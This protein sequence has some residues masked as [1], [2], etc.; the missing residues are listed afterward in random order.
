MSVVEGL[1]SLEPSLSS[2]AESM[3]T[4]ITT[5]KNASAK[6]SYYE[7]VRKTVAYNFKSS[8]DIRKLTGE[9]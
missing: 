1:N 8:F 6:G 5:C 7:I 2:L 9:W 4:T 3:Y